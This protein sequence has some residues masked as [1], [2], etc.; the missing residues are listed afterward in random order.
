MGTGDRRVKLVFD[1]HTSVHR[2]VFVQQT[3]QMHQFLKFIYFCITL[4]MFRSF[5][6]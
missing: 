2:N 3:N 1:V 4:Y 5:R 6:P